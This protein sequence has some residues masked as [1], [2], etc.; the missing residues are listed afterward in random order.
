MQTRDPPFTTQA[1]LLHQPDQTPNSA[2]PARD[3]EVEEVEI[4][5]RSIV[6]D[7]DSIQSEVRPLYTSYPLTDIN[8]QPLPGVLFFSQAK[9]LEQGMASDNPSNTE[10]P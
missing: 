6:F 8:S 3:G 2:Q 9:G 1:D 4:L 10:V 7:I 5:E